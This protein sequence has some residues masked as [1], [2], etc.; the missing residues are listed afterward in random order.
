[1]YWVVAECVMPHCVMW[2]SIPWMKA[3]CVRLNIWHTVRKI[4][5]PIQ[6][7]A[8]SN[9]QYIC[10]SMPRWVI[11]IFEPTTETTL[12]HTCNP[13]LITRQYNI[14]HCPCNAQSILRVYHKPTHNSNILLTYWSPMQTHNTLLLY[15][16]PSQTQNLLL[17]YPGPIIALWPV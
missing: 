10:Q 2:Y 4:H 17:V 14:I 13:K 1:M 15:Q 3:L 9:P 7:W 11:G 12:W 6:N 5:Q 16:G 8:N